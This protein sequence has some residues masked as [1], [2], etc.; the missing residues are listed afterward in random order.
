MCYLVTGTHAHRT[1][2]AL[3]CTSFIITHSEL[4]T[5]LWR[6]WST[7]NSVLFI[8]A[9]QSHSG[10]GADLAS[11]RWVSGTVLGV[12]GGGLTTSPQSVSRLPRNAGSSTSHKA[13]SL[14]DLIAL[15]TFVLLLLIDRRRRLRMI[16]RD[17]VY[18]NNSDKYDSIRG[19][20]KS[21]CLNI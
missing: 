7:D 10:P 17:A 20:I 13:K 9:Y 14:H 18:L 2:L 6:I 5:D 11:D 12:T 16:I 19:E 4:I 3:H 15:L 8:R 21:L 1:I